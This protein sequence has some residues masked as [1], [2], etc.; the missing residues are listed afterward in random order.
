MIEKVY[1]VRE[2]A[3]WTSSE[4]DSIE[5]K[6]MV[7]GKK[8]G[9]VTRANAAK[10]LECEVGDLITL[11]EAAS[12]MGIESFRTGHLLRQGRVKGF[13]VQ[14][15]QFKKGKWYTTIA[16]CKAYQASKGKRQ[17]GMTTVLVRMPYEAAVEYAKENENAT[18]RYNRKK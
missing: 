4:S 12:A 6:G 2:E 16:M 17:D 15:A 13:K 3:N 1:N 5:S 11:Q 8:Y 7:M 9:G 18:L 10:R 14:E